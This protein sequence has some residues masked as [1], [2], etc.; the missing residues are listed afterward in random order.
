MLNH[1]FH[2]CYL[3]QTFT[4]EKLT[5]TCWIKGPYRWSA[6]ISGLCVALR[7]DELRVPYTE[8][9][10][11]Q[12]IRQQQG[13]AAQQAP[14]QTLHHFCGHRVLRWS[15]SVSERTWPPPHMRG[16]TVRY[17][18]RSAQSKGG[19]WPS[20]HGKE[21]YSPQDGME[22]HP[23]ICVVVFYRYRLRN[24]NASLARR[25]DLKLKML[26]FYISA[27]NEIK[28]ADW[29]CNHPSILSR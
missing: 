4:W 8:G 16:L 29:N 6:I 10:C 5:L 25:F 19:T 9:V 1:F 23:I 11:G 17:V 14:E 12:Y 3:E 22:N 20:G 7:G 2:H 26:L 15:H 27:E 28:R 13:S 18:K 21:R 24:L